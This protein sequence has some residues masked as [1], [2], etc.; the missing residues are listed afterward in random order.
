MDAQGGKVT[1]HMQ[2]AA[3]AGLATP[4]TAHHI[5]FGGR[6]LNCGY[7]P[8]TAPAEQIYVSGKIVEFSWGYEQT[9]I[10]YFLITKRSAHFVWL[11]PIQ[12]KRVEDTG[13]M[14]GTCVPDP[15]KNARQQDGSDK[16]VIRRKV[17]ARDGKETGIAIESYGWASLWDEKPSRWSSYH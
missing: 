12:S 10:D 15:E 7:D 6:C 16:P 14:S 8:A 2:H 13:Y 11:Q 1:S 3:S 4:C 17:H 5:T 9:N